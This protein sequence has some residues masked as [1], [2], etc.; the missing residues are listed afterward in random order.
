MREVILGGLVTVLAAGVL[1]GCASQSDLEKVQQRVLALE[2]STKRSTKALGDRLAENGKKIEAMTQSL[3]EIKALAAKAEASAAAASKQLP[4]LRSE[5]GK[6]H[7]QFDRMNESI[8]EAQGLIIK[9]LENARDIYKTQFLALEEVLQN[10]K[11]PGAP[12][13][14]EK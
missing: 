8:A 1:G 7:T 10:L 12:K 3:E 5:M 2:S 4:T 9:N 13:P 6:F 14:P 11:K